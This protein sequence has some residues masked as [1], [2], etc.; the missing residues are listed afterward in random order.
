MGKFV[1]NGGGIMM[2]ELEVL[3]NGFIAFLDG[4]W[5]GLRDNVGALSI[6]EGYANGF[7]QMGKEAAEKRGGRGAEN[8]AKI[9]VEIFKAIGLD[10]EKVGNEVRIKS[11]PLWDRILER[12]LEYSFHLEKICW[13]PMLEGIGEKTGVSA[14]VESSLRMTHVNRSK[15]DYKKKK[16][17][18]ALEK[19]AI[20]K[21]EYKQQIVN[22]E[23]T[24][25][26][27]SPIGRYRFG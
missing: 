22:L 20:T 3:R 25:K 17:K 14:V 10:A 4:L 11:C 27:L 2:D 26:S 7:K 1:H 12:G 19:G 18:S 8:A 23:E 9:A 6:Y 5:W 13:K 21:D 24:L 15:I 16:A